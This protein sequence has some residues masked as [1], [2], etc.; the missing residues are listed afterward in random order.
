MKNN[1]ASFKHAT[2]HR[3]RISR[4]CKS[5]WQ[6]TPTRPLHVLPCFAPGHCL[7]DVD[8]FVQLAR[9]QDLSIVQMWGAQDWQ[10][11]VLAHV[12][13]QRCPKMSKVCWHLKTSQDISR[14]LKTK[15]LVWSQLGWLVIALCYAYICIL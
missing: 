15:N 4:S 13:V 8:C 14:H 11:R 10:K 12:S 2:P 3:S 6:M 1:K 7:D 9:C 5:T